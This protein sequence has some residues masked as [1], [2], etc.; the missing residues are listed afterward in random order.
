[1]NCRS[2]Y[3]ALFAPFLQ[4]RRIRGGASVEKAWGEA[5]HSSY[6]SGHRHRASSDGR[7]GP[8]YNDYRTLELEE[9]EMDRQEPNLPLLD[10]GIDLR[11]Y[12]VIA[13]LLL[14]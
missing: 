3:Y 10:T 8:E 1:M 13:P 7:F 6:E 5:K 11:P 9:I 2:D 14:V 12:L 4:A